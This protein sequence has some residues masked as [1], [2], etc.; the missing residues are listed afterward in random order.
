PMPPPPPDS[1]SKTKMIV[2]ILDIISLAFYVIMFFAIIY[3]VATDPHLAR[4]APIIIVAL[5]HIIGLSI[6]M[7]GLFCKM[8]S[9]LLA[10]FVILIVLSVALGMIAQFLILN[11][12]GWF[13]D[14]ISIPPL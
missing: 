6:G 8:P 12:C 3:G 11:A 7:G 13:Q 1:T 9:L 10:H 2:M 5:H 14:I 4:I